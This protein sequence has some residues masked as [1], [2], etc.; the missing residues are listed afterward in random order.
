MLGL[1]GGFATPLLLRSEADRPIGLFGYVLLLDL[2]LLAIGK[3]KG[4]P[5]LGLLSL[6]GTVLLQGMWIGFRMGPDRMLLGLAILAVFAVV[7][8]AASA[9]GTTRPTPGWLASQ[10]GAVLFPFVFA[11]YFASRVDLGARLYPVGVLL[12]ILSFA[13]CF[14]A[15]SGNAPWIAA[16]AAVGNLG[17]TAAWLV[18][19]TLT[20]SQA[21]ELA[22]VSV[23]LALVFH[24]FV[25]RGPRRPEIEGPSAGAI[26]AACG[27]TILLIAA[28]VITRDTS[29]APWLAGWIGLGALLIRHATLPNRAELQIPGAVGTALGL[30]LFH[31]RHA[32]TAA[33]PDLPVFLGIAL[34]VA[35]VVQA[36]ALARR[37]P[38]NRI[39][40][41]HA[42]ALAS[43]GLVG[44]CA[45][46]RIVT[47]PPHSLFLAWV[48][49]LGVLALLCASRLASGGWVAASA[50]GSLAVHW[51][52]VSRIH[53]GGDLARVG[54]ALAFLATSVALLTFWP[55][56][57]RKSF[58][59]SPAAWIA[60]ALAGP[61][62]FYPLKTLFRM[63]FGSDWI[64][65][66]PVALGAL[67]VAA[68]ALARRH[69]PRALRSGSGRSCGSRRSR[70]RS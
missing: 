18:Q 39:V 23:G 36:I 20:S 45:F 12:A 8:T 15:R 9:V 50:A 33:F 2:G 68:V 31:A 35:V 26:V 52:L 51:V 11:A 7:L 42:S 24:L 17:V 65:A 60:A 1:L 41:E 21:W 25:E 30:S 19:R 28:A 22:A 16:A 14:V 62:W 67:S 69:G 64:G 10:T 27:G 3:K 55:F 13:A 63:R 70:S 29:L 43:V 38:E 46:S 5:L 4:W 6:L 53:A 56:L 66:L 54:P 59:A 57:A 32:G 61:A 58:V 40:A 49:A 44:C 37:N 34:V 47:L 48:L